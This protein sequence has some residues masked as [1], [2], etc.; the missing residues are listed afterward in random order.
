MMDRYLSIVQEQPSVEIDEGRLRQFLSRIKGR[1]FVKISQLEYQLLPAIELFSI[2]NDYYKN[3]CDKYGSGI[4]FFCFY[5][6]CSL[7]GFLFAY[8]LDLI[9]SLSICH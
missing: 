2:L 3:M 1:D 9:F 6:F 7:Y 4:R 5:F 8:C